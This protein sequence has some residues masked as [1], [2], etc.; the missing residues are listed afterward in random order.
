MRNTLLFFCSLI[1][2]SYLYALYQRRRKDIPVFVKKTLSGNWN[3]RTIP[4]FGIFLSEK[5]KDNQLL[6][7]HEKIHW[8]QYQNMGLLKYYLQYNREIK[9]YGYDKM[10]ME[11]EARRDEN[12]YAQE[13]YTE[14]VRLGLSDTVFNPNFRK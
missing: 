12:E 10:P 5:E 13:N 3:A 1:T 9:K 6:I 7:E 2:V 14:A 8:R 4:P 11:K